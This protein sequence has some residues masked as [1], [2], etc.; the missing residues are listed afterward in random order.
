[1]HW[2]FVKIFLLILPFLEIRDCKGIGEH[3]KSMNLEIE[4]YSFKKIEFKF[5][6]AI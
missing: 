6:I 5:Y 1:M 4:A 2:I 3:M